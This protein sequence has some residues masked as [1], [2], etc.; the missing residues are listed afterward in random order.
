MQVAPELANH[1]IPHVVSDPDDFFG[2]SGCEVIK[3]QRKI[4]VARVRIEIQGDAKTVYIKRYNAVSW[5]YRVGSWFQFS[6][7]SKSLRGAAV[8][9]ESGIRTVQ[10][11][12]AI[13]TRSWGMLQRSFFLSEEIPEGN[14]AD[15]YWRELLAMKGR[16]GLRLRRGFLQDMG[17]F[18]N[19]L[20]EQGIYHND[21]KDANIVISPGPEGEGTRFYLLDLEGVQRYRMLNRRRRIKN[22]VQLHRTLGSYL[23]RPDKLR[24]LKGYLGPAFSH[25]TTKRGSVTAVLRQSER[26]DGLRA[27]KHP[28]LGRAGN[29]AQES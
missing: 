21:L 14:T 25:K 19:F 24:F 27:M 17:V 10:C 11:L 29:P 7:A 1:L 2:L 9:A 5:R 8:L 18:F 4:K 26:L 23:R 22:L 12:A 13:E 28:P 6:G 3:D 16:R 15:V 20:H